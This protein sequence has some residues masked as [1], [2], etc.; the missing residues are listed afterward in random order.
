M[1]LAPG[2]DGAGHRHILLLSG[3]GRSWRRLRPALRVALCTTGAKYS[4]LVAPRRGS[5]VLAAPKAVPDWPY[6]TQGRTR[7]VLRDPGPHSLGLTGPRAV[8]DWPC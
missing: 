7:L 6:G 4:G 3:G 1:N 8:P 5:I 2:R